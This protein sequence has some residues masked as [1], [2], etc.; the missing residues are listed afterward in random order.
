MTVPIPANETPR[1][2]ALR[3]NHILDTAPEEAFDDL[4]RLAAHICGVPIAAINFIDED[5]VWCKS[6]LGFDAT[7]T[8]REVAFCAHTILQ[9]DLLI[10]LDARN[11]VRFAAN[12]F[13]TGDPYVRFYAGVPLLTS[14]GHAL[15]S[16]CVIDRVP[17]Q[18]T[19]DQEAA[20]Q[21][22]ARQASSQLELTRRVALQD[23][24]MSEAKRDAEAKRDSE[25]RFRSYI[26]AME[27]G[28]VLRGAD[29]AILSCNDSAER[30][31]GLTAAQMT[32]LPTLDPGGRAVREDGSEFP[33]EE[34]PTMVSLREGIPQ[35]GVIMG[36]HKPGGDLA[37]ISINTIPLF[38]PGEAQ[39]HGV[40]CTFSD[41]T[42]RKRSEEERA[43]LAAIVESSHEAI[44]A[45]TLEG[46]LISWNRGAEQHYGYAP[47]LII[48]RHASV[49]APPEERGFI[50]ETIQAILRG[51]KR[52]NVEVRRQRA[53][54]TWMDLS[55]TF[56]P[57]KNAADQI[58]G[59]AAIG[60]DIS[61]QKCAEQVLRDSEEALRT[62]M[63]GAPIIL[64]AT[65]AQGVVTLSEGAGLARLGLTP[66]EVVGQSVFEMYRDVPE[67]LTNLKKTL[68]G[69]NV[70]YEIILNGLCYHNDVRPQRNQ[71]GVITGIIAVAYDL[72]ER[73]RAEEALKDFSV[74]LEFQKHELEKTNA[75]LESL[76]MV[77]GLTGLRNRRSFDTHLQE[78]FDRAARYRS[79]LS[80]VLLDID[81]FKHYN[82]TFGHLA[83]DEVLRR[84][85]A[86]LQTQM[87]ETDLLCRYGGE[88]IAIIMPE[89]DRAGAMQVA[90]RVRAAIAMASWD[91]REITV[92]LGVSTFGIEMDTP[93][94]LVAGAD[95][96]LYHSKANGRNCVTHERR[97]DATPADALTASLELV[98]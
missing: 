32:G 39:P 47:E 81:H 1:L 79:P 77:D 14:E 92:S 4:T 5:R 93:Q 66:G 33:R 54:G 52:E 76:A 83:G 46:T 25:E 56:S 82:D 10:V 7:E 64:Y 68:A 97:Y 34:Q 26:Q 41:I 31:L 57:I 27:E 55:L 42:E 18:L 40:V 90:E 65:D 23:R 13:V 70:S 21:M 22:L 63:E 78:E 60:R 48:G 80:L 35:R 89:T 75:E 17:R 24:L 72:T 71:E 88:E 38:H 36:I 3:R 20:L 62:V 37:W 67:I 19:P 15:G 87:R 2:E 91:N 84:V 74:V 44:F 43:R 51:E 86:I 58:I 49:L 8:P 28:L 69:E 12:P 6:M 85:G 61:V 11:D 9:T 94:E 95:R 53:D 16:L 73:W 30:I 98:S 59:V 45:V 96:A 50:M 29:G